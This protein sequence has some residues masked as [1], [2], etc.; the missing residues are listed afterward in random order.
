MEVSRAYY[1]ACVTECVCVSEYV[2]VR[3]HYVCVDA[4]VSEPRSTSSFSSCDDERVWR[5]GK[6][7]WSCLATAPL[8]DSALFDAGLS[9]KRRFRFSLYLRFFDISSSTAQQ[10]FFPRLRSDDTTTECGE[11][12]HL[13]VAVN[14][15]R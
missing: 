5:A 8:D 3:L 13:V 2:C 10:H 15:R 12:R 4:S 7:G 11:L 6:A 1:F 14:G 9:I